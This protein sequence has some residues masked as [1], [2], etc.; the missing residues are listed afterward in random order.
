MKAPYLLAVRQPGRKDRQCQASRGAALYK[1]AIADGFCSSMLV[2]VSERIEHVDPKLADLATLVTETALACG[3]ATS[4]QSSANSSHLADHPSS[5][6]E[7]NHV[8]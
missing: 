4:L 5:H 1:H 8:P 3:V 6:G 7:R 2:S